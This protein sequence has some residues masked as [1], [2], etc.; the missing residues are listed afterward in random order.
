MRKKGIITLIMLVMV[1]LA[2]AS[3]PSFSFLPR[4]GGM[5]YAEEKT[6]ESISQPPGTKLPAR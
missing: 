2:A 5:A 6:D 3:G 1:L 4:A